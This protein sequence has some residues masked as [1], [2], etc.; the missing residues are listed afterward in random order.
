MPSASDEN[1]NTM[2]MMNTPA[3]DS[4]D[5]QSDGTWHPDLDPD[6]SGQLRREQKADRKHHKVVTPTD[7]WQ[8]GEAVNP[9]QS[10]QIE[11]Y[12]ADPQ[13]LLDTAQTGQLAE[14]PLTGPATVRQ[15]TPGWGWLFAAAGLVIALLLFHQA[16]L[17]VF[18]VAVL[19]VQRLLKAMSA[20]DG[21][22][23]Q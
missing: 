7:I 22:G 16:G 15:G 18:I 20:A 14:Q 11:E 23:G 17:Y 19:I 9:A 21:S 8:P 13:T 1:Q 6:Y 4:G 12:H 5:A 2:N 3:T 10:V